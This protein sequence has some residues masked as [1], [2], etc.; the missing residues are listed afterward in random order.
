M[1]APL[2]NMEL[3]KTWYKH[4]TDSQRKTVHTIFTDQYKTYGQIRDAIESGQWNYLFLNEHT[5]PALQDAIDP[6]AKQLHHAMDED[7]KLEKA[8]CNVEDEECESCSS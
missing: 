2:L 7:F 3:Y 6:L 4:A 8:T 5:R 1:L